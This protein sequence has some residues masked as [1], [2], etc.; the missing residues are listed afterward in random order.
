MKDR[1]KDLQE[2]VVFLQVTNCI[3][4]KLPI[5]DELAAAVQKMDKGAVVANAQREVMEYLK[6]ATPSK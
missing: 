5:P 2:A 6:C 3:L 4:M 1:I